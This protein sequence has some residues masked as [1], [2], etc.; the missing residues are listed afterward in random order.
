MAAQNDDGEV[1]LGD[2]HEYD[3]QIEPFDKV[4]IDDLILSELRKIIRLPDWTIAERWHGI[5]SKTL[6]PCFEAEPLHKVHVCTGTGG[7][8]MTMAF[9]IA[10]RA[11]KR[12]SSEG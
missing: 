8:G 1:I 7:A 5:Y 11:W 12:W 3:Q 9:G 2:S 4:V 6:S 10:E